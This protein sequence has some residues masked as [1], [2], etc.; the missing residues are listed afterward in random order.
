MRQWSLFFRKEMLEMTRSYKWL[1]VPIV[2]L[3]Y[4]V[5][6]PIS[7][8]FLP[9]ILKHAGNMPE[10]TIINIPTPTGPEELAQTLGQYDTIGILILVLAMMGIL[11][12]ERQSGVISMIF[13]KPISYLSYVGAKWASIIALSGASFLIGYAGAWYYS[14][15]LMSP[16][17]VGAAIQGALLYVLWLSFIGSLLLF[18]SSFLNS[19][20][21]IAFTTIGGAVILSVLSG[22]L[23]RYLAWS[24]SNLS[25]M[26]MEFIQ[27]GTTSMNLTAILVLSIGCIVACLCGTVLVISRRQKV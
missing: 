1:W 2:F 9:D 22:L 17:P 8:Y 5:M 20:A 16:I 23:P 26:A 19:A 15:F 14:H 7:M 27:T 25:K 4:G 12:A 21:A 10:G 11:S 24:P 13:V 3:L 18:V 6:Q